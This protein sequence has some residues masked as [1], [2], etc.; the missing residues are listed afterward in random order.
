[1]NKKGTIVGYKN[2]ENTEKINILRKY[3]NKKSR[4]HAICH[5]RFPQ[6]NP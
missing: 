2:F 1:M 5:A 4:K 3:D 6:P